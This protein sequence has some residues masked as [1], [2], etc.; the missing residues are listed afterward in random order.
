MHMPDLDNDFR[1][2]EPDFAV[3]QTLLREGFLGDALTSNKPQNMHIQLHRSPAG[4][5]QRAE[6]DT[7][8][9][10]QIDRKLY[11]GRDAR[12][13]LVNKVDIDAN[14]DGKLDDVLTFQRSSRDP[15]KLQTAKIDRGRDGSTN[16]M[17]TYYRSPA[18]TGQ[19]S[20]I[21][22]EQLGAAPS[23]D[24][25]TFH[26]SVGPG[27]AGTLN[28]IT[29][30]AKQ[31]GS[32]NSS[33]KFNHNQQGLYSMNIDRNADGTYDSHLKINRNH[34]QEVDRILIDRNGKGVYDSTM[35]I[36]RDIHR[37]TNAIDIK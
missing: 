10:K 31:D 36:S 16:E 22:Y 20:A 33:I 24:R 34:L 37:R 11:F 2:I 12:T 14:A 5:I 1:A 32:I 18:G 15:E 9:D 21:K 23:A 3:A 4:E 30:D 17:W 29:M 26:R 25:A 19:L 13:G 27:L 6:I 28:S 35:R 7:N 8:N